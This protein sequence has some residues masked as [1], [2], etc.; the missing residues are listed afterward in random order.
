MYKIVKKRAVEAVTRQIRFY[1][2]LFLSPFVYQAVF[3]YPVTLNSRLRQQLSHDLLYETEVAVHAYSTMEDLH[4]ASRLQ[5]SNVSLEEDVDVFIGTA[6]HG[7]TFPGVSQP[8]GMVQ[9]SPDNGVIGYDWSS[10]YHY[11]STQV[12]GFS[13]THLSGT[14]I[15]E[16]MDLL[17]MPTILDVPNRKELSNDALSTLLEKIL[18]EPF[19]APGYFQ[20]DGGALSHLMRSDIDHK[21]E[22]AAPGYYRVKLLKHGIDVELTATTYCGVHRYNHVGTKH[23]M[24]VLVVD[25]SN[26]LFQGAAVGGEIKI[27]SDQKS[28]EGFRKTSGWAGQRITYFHIKFSKPI[29]SYKIFKSSETLLWSPCRLS[30]CQTA[31]LVFDSFENLQLR[32]GISSADTRGAEKAVRQLNEEYGWDFD[33]LRE[34]TAKVWQ[35]KLGQ[36]TISEPRAEHARKI[37]YTS[38]YHALLAPTIHS[39]INNAYTG[40]DKKKHIVEKSRIMYS[41]FSLWDTFRAENSLHTILHPLKARDMAMS[42]IEY[43]KQQ[44]NLL[45]VWNL[46]G[47]ETHTMPGYHAASILAEAGKKKLLDRNELTMAFRAMNATARRPMSDKAFLDHIGYIPKD[48]TT[49]SVTKT[50]EYAFD[51]WCIAQVGCFSCSIQISPFMLEY[52]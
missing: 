1:H 14:G 22:T 29:L 23:Q 45:P 38:L 24:S 35:Q 18:I 30:G 49:E 13:H 10:G 26:V 33:A 28:L 6:G 50:L 47:Q 9:V 34:S 39:D 46:A 43:S 4:I 42:L 51:D 25:L 8:F 32:V 20:F 11:N 21:Q 41:T 16:L 5:E 17:I 12:I 44:D 31:F 36:I 3:H 15:G 40:S 52:D 2:L 27:L 19:P 37:F 48:Q 7:H